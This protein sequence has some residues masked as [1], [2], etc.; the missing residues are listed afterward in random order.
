MEVGAGD[1][2]KKKKMII[3]GVIAAVIVIM[4]IAAIVLSAPK[5]QVNSTKE[6]LITT[7]HLRDGSVTYFNTSMSIKNAN[8]GHPLG[9]D[10]VFTVV[11]SNT[12]SSNRVNITGFTSNTQGFLFM[13][14]EPMPPITLPTS[15]SGVS[16]ELR[17]TAPASAWNGQ[18]EFTVF[19][20]QYELG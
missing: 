6:N 12:N 10:L 14:S 15:P 1:P 16:V 17:F 20:E 7:I 13:S 11:Y 18:F 4:L 9:Q 19:F 5:V 8:G 2:G 3:Y